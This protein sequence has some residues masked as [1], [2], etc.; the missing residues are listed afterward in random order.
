MFSTKLMLS[1]SP[2]HN[3]MS[4]EVKL[5]PAGYCNRG[6]VFVMYPAEILNGILDTEHVF[7]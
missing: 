4:V 5:P 6:L 2:K 3:I 7:S 1:P